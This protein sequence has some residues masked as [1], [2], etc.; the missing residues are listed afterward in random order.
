MATQQQVHQ[1]NEQRLLTEQRK[2]KERYPDESGK[3]TDPH[4]KTKPIPQGARHGGKDEGE[5]A[6]G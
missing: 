6:I 2:P 1:P 4:D 5:A 3:R